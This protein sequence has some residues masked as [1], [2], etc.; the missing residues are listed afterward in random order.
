M[1]TMMTWGNSEGTKGRCDAKC[2]TAKSPIDKCKCM[3]GGA[4]HGG[5]RGDRIQA[6]RSRFGPEILDRARK[7]A[8]DLGYTIRVPDRQLQLFEPQAD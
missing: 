7:R 5:A 1:T 8:Q 6:I 3:C 4:Y 2:H